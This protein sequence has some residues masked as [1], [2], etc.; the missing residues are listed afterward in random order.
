MLLVL[1]CFFQDSLYVGKCKFSLD[2]DH[3]DWWGFV[4]YNNFGSELLDDDIGDERRLLR[5]PLRLRSTHLERNMFYV[6]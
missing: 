1:R 4:R 6:L 3:F 2:D 5:S